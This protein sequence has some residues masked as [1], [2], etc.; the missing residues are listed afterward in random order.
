MRRTQRIWNPHA[1]IFCFSISACRG[2]QPRWVACNWKFWRLVVILIKIIHFIWA[3]DWLKNWLSC[4]M[5]CIMISWSYPIIQNMPV[6]KEFCNF[7]R[8]VLDK[9]SSC[10]WQ[11]TDH[12]SCEIYL[13]VEGIMFWKLRSSVYLLFMG[14][15]SPF[16]SSP[17]NA[18]T[19]FLG[20]ICFTMYSDRPH[21]SKKRS[22]IFKLE[23]KS[24][25]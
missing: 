5:N 15:P 8:I 1:W 17:A 7:P 6:G 24:K 23:W 4:A 16:V 22:N 20:S 13:L 14:E 25:M 3:F 11:S 18:V 19:L 12:V 21:H 10:G 9:E 2:C